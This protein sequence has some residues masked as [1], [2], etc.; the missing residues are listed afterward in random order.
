MIYFYCDSTLFLSN[1]YYQNLFYL[2]FMFPVTE[3]DEMKV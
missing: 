2:N 3:T 1:K